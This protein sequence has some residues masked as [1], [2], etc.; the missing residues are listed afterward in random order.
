[1]FIYIE[2]YV[3]PRPFLA[4]LG[5]CKDRCTVQPPRKD[6]AGEISEPQGTRLSEP[7]PG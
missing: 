4:R 7:D 3:G 5:E 2:R 1:M 6:L